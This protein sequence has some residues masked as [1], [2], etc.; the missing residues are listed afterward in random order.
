MLGDEVEGLTG[1]TNE[2][3]R[4]PNFSTTSFQVFAILDD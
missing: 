2:R 1:E 4:F 3:S